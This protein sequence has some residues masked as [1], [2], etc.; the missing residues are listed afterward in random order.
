MRNSSLARNSWPKKYHL[1]E[2]EHALLAR[3]LTRLG[4]PHFA[5]SSSCSCFCAALHFS[6]HRASRVLILFYFFMFWGWFSFLLWVNSKFSSPAGAGGQQ[7]QRRHIEV[8]Y[9][10]LTAGLPAQGSREGAGNPLTRGLNALGLRTL[11]RIN[12]PIRRPETEPTLSDV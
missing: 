2:P 1:P 4:S 6:A 10:G 9:A 3:P 7:Q 5:S 8:T 11:L 12:H